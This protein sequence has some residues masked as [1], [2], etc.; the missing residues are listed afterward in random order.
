MT[1]DQKS[2][3]Q[4]RGCSTTFI[5]IRLHEPIEGGI[6]SKPRGFMETREAG[7]G[8]PVKPELDASARQ[9]SK[10]LTSRMTDMSIGTLK[11]RQR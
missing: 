6:P 1:G 5:R 3:S 4:T 9:A 10:I 2:A 11:S 8:E 7:E